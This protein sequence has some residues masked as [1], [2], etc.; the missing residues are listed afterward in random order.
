[1]KR[2]QLEKANKIESDIKRLMELDKVLVQSNNGVNKLAA[3]NTDC[4][5]QHTVISDT[6]IPTS[7]F[8]KFRQIIADEVL[9]LDAEFEAL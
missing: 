4:Y 7:I 1:M 8:A 2:E 5:G 3:V 9:R 6:M